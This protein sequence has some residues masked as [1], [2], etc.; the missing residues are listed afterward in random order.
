VI[1]QFK[2]TKTKDKVM[3]YDINQLNEI[4]RVNEWRKSGV[5]S[6]QQALYNFQ[7][8]DDESCLKHLRDFY[9]CVEQMVKIQKD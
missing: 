1:P 7:S 8:H 5:E 4:T 9:F 2:Q 3:T 6:L